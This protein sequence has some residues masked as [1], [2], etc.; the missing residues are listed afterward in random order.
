ML[1]RSMTSPVP[2]LE[3]RAPKSQ[4]LCKLNTGYTLN[5]ASGKRQV[6]ASPR[7]PTHKEKPKQRVLPG[8]RFLAASLRNHTVLFTKVTL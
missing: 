6:N 8:E 1:H 2:R 5:E 4:V 3:D 7:L